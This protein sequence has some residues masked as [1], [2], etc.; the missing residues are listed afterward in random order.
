MTYRAPHMAAPAPRP[1]QG[2]GRRRGLQGRVAGARQGL[3]LSRRGA[4]RACSA[5]AGAAAA[6][7]MQGTPG[8]ARARPPLRRVVRNRVTTPQRGLTGSLQHHRQP[9]VPRQL[10]MLIWRADL[11]DSNSKRQATFGDSC[12]W[13]WEGAQVEPPTPQH[14]GERIAGQRRLDQGRPWH[15]LA[16]KVPTSK[17]SSESADMMS[18][19]DRSSSRPRSSW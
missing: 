5:A 9:E 6:L 14:T 1:P 18:P 3:A 11:A 16:R 2:A 19:S 7:C 4:G 12:V 15:D 10:D 17:F 8:H 13:R